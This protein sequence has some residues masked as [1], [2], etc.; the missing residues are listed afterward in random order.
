MGLAVNDSWPVQMIALGREHEPFLIF[1]GDSRWLT[2][3]NQNGPAEQFPPSATIRKLDIAGSPA[4]LIRYLGDD[5][6][7]LVARQGRIVQISGHGV[8]DEELVQIVTSLRPLTE[9]ELRARLT[10]EASN[11]KPDLSLFWPSYLPDG[12]QL[13]PAETV[14]ESP[15][16][17]HHEIMGY[18]VSFRSTDTL[19]Q[20]GGG[21]VDIPAVDG[22]HEKVV[23]GSLAGDLTTA[24]RRFLLVLGEESTADVLRFPGAPNDA[25]PRLPNVQQG[26]IFI[27]AENIDRETFDRVV[28]GLTVVRLHDFVGRAHGEASGSTRYWLPSELP[29]GFTI[30]RTSIRVGWDD[31]ILQGGRPFFEYALKSSNN[32]VVIARGGAELGGAALVAPEGPGVERVRVTVHGRTAS[33][34]RTPEGS[35]IVWTEDGSTTVLSSPSLTIEQ[36]VAIGEA[37]RPV[38]LDAFFDE[39]K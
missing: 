22:T 14:L 12:L 35:S 25:E 17:M 8:S 34:A 24:D 31:Y 21:H 23:S 39:I 26:P 4:V 15:N 13:T 3:R 9:A 33:A 6:K 32:E 27:M 10:Q 38:T 16:E 7:L 1:R 18:R 29:D 37:L 36:L 30:D 2:I 5:A 28:A 19:I 11:Q 20:I